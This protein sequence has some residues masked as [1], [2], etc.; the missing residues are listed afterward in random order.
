M[1]TAGMHVWQ[2]ICCWFHSAVYA[3]LGAGEILGMLHKHERSTLMHYT[4]LINTTLLH[5]WVSY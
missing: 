3:F 1:A 4:Q 2:Q 5:C